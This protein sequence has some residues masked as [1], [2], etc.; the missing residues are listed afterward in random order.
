MKAGVI[1]MVEDEF[2]VVGSFTD[3]VTED[4]HELQRCLVIDRVFS[5][6]SGEM[7]F[8]GR[9]AADVVSDTT[10][11]SISSGDIDVQRSS[12]IETQFTEFV[13][14]SGEFVVVSSSDGTFAFDLIAH[15][16]GTSIDRA[17]LDLDAF[18]SDHESATPWKVGV[19]DTGNGGMNG[20]FHGEDLRSNHDLAEIIESST[21]NQ[22]GLSHGYGGSDVK[23]TASRSG[24]AEVYRPSDFDSTEYLEYLNE[25]ILPFVT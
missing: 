9:A 22:V 4:G 25:E 10:T 6:Q 19:N 20:I 12:Q 1:G 16:T 18:F 17:T 7:A 3:T 5:L 13:G 15:E 14:V 21:L 2:D 11:A 23:M 24:Y 8:A